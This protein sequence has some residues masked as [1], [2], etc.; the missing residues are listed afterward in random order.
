MP[1]KSILITCPECGEEGA[2]EIWNSIDLSENPPLEEKIRSGALYRY[3][4][5]HCGIVTKIAYPTLIHDADRKRMIYLANDEETFR[6]T[7]HQYEPGV[8]SASSGLLDA[9]Y[10]IRVLRSVPELMERFRI[11]QA[12]L[13]DRVIE[14][15]KLFVYQEVMDNNPDLSIDNLYFTESDEQENDYAF[16]LFSHGEMIGHVGFRREAYDNLEQMFASEME[17]L[18][19]GKVVIDASWASEVYAA[20][21]STQ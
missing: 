12:E 15:M 5:P 4:C 3:A 20:H 1:S 6:N 19:A 14:L 16:D 10:M 7:V 9:G 21:D 8:S 18:S 11:L 13:D 2:F 17:R